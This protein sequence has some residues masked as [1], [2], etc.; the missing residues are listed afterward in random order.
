[1]RKIALFLSV[2]MLMSVFA[3]P[4]LAAEPR[5]STVVPELTIE[6][7]TAKCNVQVVGE[8]TSDV[9]KAT[10][11]LWRGNTCIATWNRESNG[12]IFF[13][14][15]KTIT[16]GYTYTLTVDATVDGTVFPRASVSCEG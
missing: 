6:G 5:M 10:I 9:V 16:A 1:M 15:T 8:S 13:S 14:Q 12:Y 3:L 11:K 7:T 4:A 2:V